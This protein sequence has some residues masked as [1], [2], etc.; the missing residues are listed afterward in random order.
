MTEPGGKAAG[1]QSTDVEMEQI[2]E[3]LV[4]EIL[5]RS[6]ARIDKLEA[7]LKDLEGEI[8]RGLDALSARIGSV[9][10]ETA[11]EQQAA[12]EKLSQGVVELG[13]RIRSL[14]KG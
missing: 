7:R 4:G 1:P 3:L 13:E 5:R 6:D 10:A 2:R 8:T 14:G 9:G 11:A 12:F